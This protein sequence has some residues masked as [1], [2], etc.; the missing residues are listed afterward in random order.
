MTTLSWRYK[1]ID[2]SYSSELD[3][4]GTSLASRFV[5][6][7]RE[8]HADEIPF[9]CAFEWCA[10]PGFIGFALLAEGLCQQLVL[11]DINPVAVDAARATVVANGLQDRVRVYASDNLRQIPEEERFDLVVSN[12]PNYYCLNPQHPWYAELSGD[13]RPNDPGWVLHHAFYAGISGFLNPGALLVIEEVDPYA[14]KCFLPNEQSHL[15]MWGPEPF[16]IRPRP[17]VDDFCDMIEAA[18]LS[19]LRTVAMPHPSVPVHL[20][21]SRHD[22]GNRQIRLRERLTVYERVGAD[23]QGRYEVIATVEERFKGRL[24]VDEQHLWVV[25]LIELLGAAGSNGRTAGELAAKLER[26]ESEVVAQLAR[27]DELGW[28]HAPGIRAADADS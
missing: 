10:G 21:V 22:I 6:Y 15:P 20:M 23:A 16:D 27:L 11:A 1:D 3:G 9:D 17:P 4:D 25:D 2:V 12:P 8:S 26:Q 28:V 7:L 19:Y 13:I 24:S 14:E 18:G 5:D